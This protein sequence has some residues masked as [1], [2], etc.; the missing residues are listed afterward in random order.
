[1]AQKKSVARADNVQAPPAAQL[2]LCSL[3]PSFAL[4]SLCLCTWLF[5]SSLSPEASFLSQRRL[6]YA[7]PTMQEECVHA[8]NL[9]TRAQPR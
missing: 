9:N 5:P 1:M 7:C 6:S 2:S 8:R 3:P 4:S